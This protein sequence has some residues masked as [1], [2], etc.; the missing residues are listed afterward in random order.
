M[1]YTNRSGFKACTF[2]IAN[3]ALLLTVACLHPDAPRADTHSSSKA[4]SAIPDWNGVWVI[5]D[6]F[7]DKQ[8]GASVAAPG[9]FDPSQTRSANLP[10]FK[11]DY[12]KKVLEQQ[13]AQRDGRPVQ[14]RGAQ[15]L[16]QGMPSFWGGPYAFEIVQT[17]KQINVYQEWNEQTRRLYLDGRPHPSA[18]VLD[19]SY[20][21]H[22]IG[23]WQ[24]G[25]LHVDTVAIRADTQLRSGVGSVGGNHSEDLHITERFTSEGKDRLKVEETIEDDKALEKPWLLVIHLHRKQ[26]MQVA[27]YVCEENNRNPV[28]DD[29]VTRTTLKSQ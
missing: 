20:N 9:R 27:E 24:A 1:I 2:A 7:M 22:S 18:D 12:L 14:D 8:D 23:T 6:S 16:P 13:N 25:V 11:G 15:C 26:N 17:D 5:A 29:G 10:L 19:P 28:G 4:K 21:G 3:A